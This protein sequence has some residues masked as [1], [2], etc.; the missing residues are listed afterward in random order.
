M[1][2]ERTQAPAASA[3]RRRRWARLVLA[4][5]YLGA[6]G[7]LT[8]VLFIRAIVDPLIGNRFSFPMILAAVAASVWLG[9][10]GPALLVVVVGYFA[11]DFF[12][13]EPRYSLGIHGP[14]D[15]E[16]LAAYLVVSL[17]VV[18]FGEAA[19]RSR[20]R[21]EERADESERAR[22]LL[23]TIL[24][25]IPVGITVA[26]GAPDFPVVANSEKAQQF[27]ASPPQSLVGMPAGQ[28][29]SAFGFFRPDG[30]TRPAP[31]E[32]PLYRAVH[33][34]ESVV[35]EE[36]LLVGP[37]GGRRTVAV[38][39]APIRMPDGRIHG[40]VSCW[41]DVTEQKRLE[42]SLRE[43]SEQLQ[44]VT[45]G[46][47]A[48]VA[49]CTR[50]MRYAWVSRPYAEWL[51][52]R[53]EDIIGQPIADIIGQQAF[54]ALRPRFERVL[55]GDV[56]RYEERVNYASIGPRWVSA[57]Y[58]PTFD[59]TGAPDGW[60]S[61]VTDIDERKRAEET[62][63]ESD[64]R[65]DEFL[66]MLGHE[67]RNPLA[68]IRNAVQILN[69]LGS[70]PGPA[71]EARAIID[72][73]VTH[74][75][76][77]LDDLLDVSRIA[78]G[79]IRLR[80]QEC[81]LAA[82]VRQVAE[83]YRWTM[84]AGELKL[85]ID[86]EESVPVEG[87]PARLAQVLGNLLHNARKFT[88]A[89]GTVSVRLR[90]A[91][92]GSVELSV[93][94]TGI[95]IDAAMLPRVFEPFAQAEGNLERSGGGLGMGL[96]LVKGIV[97]LH[98]GEVSAESEGAGR[99]S[100]FTIRLPEAVHEVARASAP[101]DDAGSARSIRVLVIE[102]HADTA[103]SLRMLLELS[104]HEAEVV[105]SG[106]EGIEAAARFRPEVIF[107]DIGLP[108]MDGYEV[109][110]ALR[111]NETLGDVYLVAL[112][113]Y[114]Q[115][116]DRQLAR[117]AGFDLHLTKPINFDLVTKTLGRMLSNRSSAAGQTA[118]AEAGTVPQAH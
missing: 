84:M 32:M 92:P 81:D 59:A 53:P 48:A 88:R 102:D 34:G 35:N 118:S 60:V 5:R 43:L 47:S 3:S 45:E 107:C 36:L 37:D 65:K 41:R 19:R 96:A 83:D 68:P 1:G 95:G 13:T 7:V 30:K 28:H 16:R 98:G 70:A 31:E 99:G 20:V 63:R 97:E 94:D 14:L 2:E 33:S 78:R 55:T 25:H 71:A 54:E 11:G 39:V 80:K 66:A 17:A 49:H 52:R 26:E 56:V 74:M 76:R 82:I 40:A 46:M 117:E 9:G 64:R 103:S 10:L 6:A 85:E 23:R 22:A 114:G 108:G 115:E 57:A 50:D 58:T 77:L 51:G 62:L 38:D 61:V 90:R 110:R 8:L 104:G 91:K 44:I 116:R 75:T 18:G 73:Q 100:V 29:A 101:A 105:R 67:L 93:R 42:A 4:G 24:K 72:R 112:T 12:F 69:L 111:Q 15:I 87:D 109:A 86:A 21:A 106:R 113:G 89:G 79:K 27:L